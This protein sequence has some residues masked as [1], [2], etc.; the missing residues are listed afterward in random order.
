MIADV[1]SKVDSGFTD[2][3]SFNFNPSDEVTIQVSLAKF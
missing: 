3:Q 1:H 2:D